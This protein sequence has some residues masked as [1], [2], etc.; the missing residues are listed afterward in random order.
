MG[1]QELGTQFGYWK[2]SGSMIEREM[3]LDVNVG[4]HWD[5]KCAWR[6]AY[7]V[8]DRL[9]CQEVW[10]LLDQVCHGLAGF[11]IQF[12]CWRILDLWLVEEMT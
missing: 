5:L 6:R 1:W 8:G 3:T 4:L 7:L 10:L 2:K 9:K 11:E 12:G